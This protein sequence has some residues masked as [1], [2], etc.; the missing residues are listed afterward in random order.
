MPANQRGTTKFYRRKMNSFSGWDDTVRTKLL[1]AKSQTVTGFFL[2]HYVSDFPASLASMWFNESLVVQIHPTK[3]FGLASIADAVDC[4][5][6]GKNVGK[7]V[8]DLHNSSKL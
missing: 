1:L 4:M 7:V 6:Q 3:Y 8:V 2:N 5:H